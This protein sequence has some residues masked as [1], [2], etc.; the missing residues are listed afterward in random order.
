MIDRTYKNEL[1]RVFLI[2]DLPEPLTRANSH[3]QIFDNYIENTRL[4]LRSV[5]VP[6]TKKWSWVLEHRFPADGNDLSVWKVAEM[7]LNENEYHVFEQF[8]GREIRK[9]RYFY[10][11]DGK[12]LEFDVFIGKLWGLN[13]AKVVFGTIEE[14]QNFEIPPLMIREATNNRFFI[15]ENLVGKSFT[16]VQKEFQVSG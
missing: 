8:E 12:Q 5:R 10:E 6:E 1:R 13:M 2:R 7:F 15:G 4:R 16:D 14:M 3:L 9:N 11:L